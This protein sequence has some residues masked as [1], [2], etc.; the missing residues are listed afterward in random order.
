M[1]PQQTSAIYAEPGR[2]SS[3]VGSKV[4]FN[5]P[6]YENIGPNGGVEGGKLCDKD[7]MNQ[8][9]EGLFHTYNN[10]DDLMK[11]VRTEGEGRLGGGGGSRRDKG[12]G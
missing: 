4:N 8:D 12:R 6:T 10:Q 1:L 3:A 5:P 2:E 7:Y 9:P 11:Q